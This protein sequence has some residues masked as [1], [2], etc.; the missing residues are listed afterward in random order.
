MPHNKIELHNEEYVHLFSALF[1]NDSLGILVIN[2]DGEIVMANDY[3]LTL[4]E[5]PSPKDIIGEKVEILIPQR[6]RQH[7]VSDRN[8]FIEKPAKRPMGIG[9]DLFGRKKTG[10][11]FPSKLA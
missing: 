5:Y 3:L 9:R 6:F 2:K 1:Q 11:E 8:H 7:H 4:F 10:L